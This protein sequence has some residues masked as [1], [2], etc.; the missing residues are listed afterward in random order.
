MPNPY[1]RITY[2]VNVTGTVEL[3]SVSDW[4]RILYLSFE[5]FP[6]GLLVSHKP[7]AK[8]GGTCLGKQRAKWIS[9]RCTVLG[10]AQKLPEHSPEQLA[11]D[12]P[13]SAR[14]RDQ[15]TSTDS[16]QP[17]PF[18]GFMKTKQNQKPSN[19]P[20]TTEVLTMRSWDLS[21]CTTCNGGQFYSL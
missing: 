16:F 11:L 14:R 20:K 13:A 3:R 1:Q 9:E 21:Y 4:K 18:C 17:Q 2:Q 12:G 5:D 15:V 6:A 8:S 7:P 10:D 19:Q